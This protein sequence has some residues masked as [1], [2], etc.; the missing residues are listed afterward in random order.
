M[1]TITIRL[2]DEQ[3]RVIQGFSI[4]KN[5]TVS[6]VVLSSI[7]EKIEDEEDYQLALMAAESP[8]CLSSISDLAEECDIDYDAL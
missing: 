1:A 3:K 7:L 5:S 6:E 2:T 8:I 4:L